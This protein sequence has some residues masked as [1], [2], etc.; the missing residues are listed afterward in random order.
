MRACIK[1]T[2]LV[3]SLLAACGGRTISDE[4]RDAGP[5][6]DAPVLVDRVTPGD[7]VPVTPPDVV[8]PDV[9]VAPPDVVRPC[10]PGAVSCGGVCRD[11]TRDPSHCGR[12]NNAC[13]DGAMCSNGACVALCRPGSVPCGGRCVDLLTDTSHCGACGRRCGDGFAC[14][15]GN[16]TGEPCPPGL[17]NCGEGC[18]SLRDDPSNCGA[19]GVSCGEGP[20]VAGRCAPP[21]CP[22]GTAAC[23]ADGACT[24]LLIT[25]NHCGRCN[26][27]CP[28]AQSCLGGS[29]RN[30]MTR[31]PGPVFRVNSLSADRC[32]AVEHAMLT[33]DDRGGIA[34]NAD[35]AVYV[36]DE[37]LAM[38][39]PR[40]GLTAERRVGEYGYPVSDLRSGRIYL[41]GDAR[42]PLPLAAQ[43]PLTVSVLWLLGPAG[44]LVGRTMLS[45]PI[46]LR[47]SN[48]PIGIYAGYGRVVLHDDVALYDI[49]P[50]NGSV[51]VVAYSGFSG[52]MQCETNATWGVVESDGNDIA[53]LAVTSS[54]TISRHDRVSGRIS[55]AFTFQ[56]LSDMCS[57]T[58]V[59]SLGRW[60]FHHEGRSQFRTGDETI[61]TCLATFGM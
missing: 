61:G 18:V 14:L 1:P 24:D 30:T 21:A 42:A 57:F 44:E 34:A 27:R 7:D 6:T 8:T 31:L 23:T 43:V 41:L 32:I 22:S 17:Q 46:S 56:N 4:Y 50:S 28:D 20:C 52:R 51:R 47:S 29:C 53:L 40:G 15:M 48:T 33:G 54:T 10:G 12:C 37:S 60:V 35:V 11:V 58:V 9:P 25:R 55:Q 49:D 13:P 16:C 3:A 26:N 45:E 5:E 19:C 59:P 2:L 38:F 36:G 39:S